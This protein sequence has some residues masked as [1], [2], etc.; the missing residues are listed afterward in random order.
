MK[1]ELGHVAQLFRA[2]LRWFFKTCSHFK[3]NKTDSDCINLSGKRYSMSGSIYFPR[4]VDHACFLDQS[5]C[6]EQAPCD[7]SD[8][9]G[10][11]AHA[12]YF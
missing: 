5:I 11:D 2:Y 1:R 6:L 3:R 7:D 9:D 10:Q 4:E 8:T 12:G